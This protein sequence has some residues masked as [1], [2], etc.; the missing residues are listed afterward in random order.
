MLTI[1][2]GT[3]KERRA[4]RLDALLS[5]FR[6][7]KAEIR[8]YTDVSFSPSELEVLAGSATLFGGHGAVV[9]SSVADDTEKRDQLE[10]L[11]PVLAESSEQFIISESSLLA[12]FIKKAKSAGTE[13][14]TFESKIN[15]KKPEVFNTFLL[16]DAFCAGNRKLTWALYR[17][18]IS[19]G[20]DARELHSKIFWAVKT[21]LVA[22]SASS[23]KESGLHPF[24]YG[25]AKAS[26][27]NFPSGELKRVAIDLTKLFHDTMHD[28]LDLE[29]TFEAFLLKSL[30]AA[31]P[32][33][34]LSV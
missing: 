31:T 3:D 2:V 30:G 29:N 15:A 21:M 7:N 16:T 33:G 19:A 23:A 11:L 25:K 12:P 24:V 18:G 10:K 28:G 5:P 22:E 14:E 6:K 9:L 17:K 4:K 27:K 13:V 32:Q 8:T 1:L 26:A 34:K 20:L